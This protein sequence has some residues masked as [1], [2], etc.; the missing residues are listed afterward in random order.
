M[1]WSQ[2]GAFLYLSAGITKQNPKSNVIAE[3]TDPHVFKIG[4]DPTD[5]AKFISIEDHLPVS[6]DRHCIVLCSNR[7]IICRRMEW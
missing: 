7:C 1:T 3:V 5:P 2:D 6:T 4:V